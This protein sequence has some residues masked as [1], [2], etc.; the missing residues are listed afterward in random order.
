MRSRLGGPGRDLRTGPGSCPPPCAPVA[1]SPRNAAALAPAAGPQK[2]DPPEQARPTA[3]RSAARRADRAYGPGK[4]RPGLPA[5]PRGIAEPGLPGQR[6]RGPAGAETTADTASATAQ[7][8]DLAAV[9]ANTSDH[10]A[11]VRLLPCRLRGHPQPGLG[12]LCHGSRQ[13]PRAPS[14]GDSESGRAVDRAAGAEPP[15]VAATDLDTEQIRR[16]PVLGGLINQYT[17]A[18]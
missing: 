7:R 6:L 4:P 2:L 3:G 9:P 8:R 15:R 10:H 1:W 13:P 5:H 17:Y 11:G 18:A 14:R 16:K 12:V